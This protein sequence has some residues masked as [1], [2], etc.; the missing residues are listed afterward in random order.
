LV[1]YFHEVLTRL[2]L[3]IERTRL[4]RHD[5]RGL[6]AWRRGGFQKFGCFASLQRRS[7]SPYSG[8]KLACHFVPGP[9]LADGD[10]TGLFVGITDIHDRWDWDGY[11][12]PALLDAEIL[13][14]E[15]GRQ[16]L[17]AFDL[18]WVAAGSVYAERILV[19]WGPPA[20]ARACSQWAG[21]QHKQVLELRLDRREPPFPGFSRFACRITK[22][23]VLPQAWQGALSSVGGVYLLV[24]DAGEQY[25]GSATGQEHFLG[26]WLMYAAN[27]HGGNVLLRQRGHR[28][29]TVSILELASPDMSREDILAR[30]AHWKQ[31][32]GARAH[33]L[34]LN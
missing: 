31:K 25:V 24:S 32:L 16:D 14:A 13:E 26:R 4:L 7:P 15:R 11:R 34:N 18:A 17:H 28:D 6:V 5:S 20:G 30:E 3:E 19:R 10:A 23:P 12:L 22:I 1:F 33:G 21:R 2:G 27:G 8:A 9:P 29:Y